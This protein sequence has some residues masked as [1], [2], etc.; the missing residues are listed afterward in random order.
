LTIQSV[1]CLYGSWDLHLHTMYE[2]LASA[3]HYR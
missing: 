3:G 1:Y 2:Y